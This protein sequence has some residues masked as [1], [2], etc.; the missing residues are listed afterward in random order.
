MTVNDIIFL[1]YFHYC[2][3]KQ[4]YDLFFFL[5][6]FISTCLQYVMNGRKKIVN[7]IIYKSRMKMY[8]IFKTQPKNDLSPYNIMHSKL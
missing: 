7:G 6:I 3:R 5:Y 4:Q 8:Y 2:R 1:I